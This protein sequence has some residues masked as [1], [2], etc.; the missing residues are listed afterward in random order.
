MR[1]MPPMITSASSA[2]MNM[3]VISGSR[4]KVLSSPAAILLIWGRLPVPKELSTVAMANSTASHFS[5]RPFS[6]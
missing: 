5:L 4:L 3:A 1:V 6:M 2:D